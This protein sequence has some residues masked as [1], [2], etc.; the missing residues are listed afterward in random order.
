MEPD[1][2][3]LLQTHPR[4]PATVIA[5]RI[6][7]TRGLTVLKERIRGLRPVYLPADPAGRTTYRPGE[8]AQWDLWFPPVDI[9]IG[10]ERVS[11]PPVLTG[12]RGYSRWMVG[13]MIP[14]RE[15]HDLLLGHLAFLLELRRVP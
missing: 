3:R 6:D 1:I 5:E 13:R 8:L 15:S 14:S 11:R 7:W 4:M 10:Q 12:V 2:R 9:P